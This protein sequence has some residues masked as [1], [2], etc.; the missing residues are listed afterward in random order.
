MTNNRFVTQLLLN[1]GNTPSILSSTDIPLFEFI[2]GSAKST[3]SSP[4]NPSPTLGTIDVNKKT[5]V[6]KVIRIN[7]ANSII[8]IKF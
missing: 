3:K 7:D 4:R 6:C 8:F 2:P 5:G 1:H